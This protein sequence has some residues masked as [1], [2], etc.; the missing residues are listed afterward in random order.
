M[1]IG[2]E[3][4]LALVKLAIH[5]DG[6]LP[7]T[8]VDCAIDWKVVLEEA[9]KQSLAGVA[10][11]GFKRWLAS[12]TSN[13][14]DSSIDKRL[15]TDWFA[16]TESIREDNLRVN[17]RTAQVCHNFAKDGL[18]TSVMK[19]QGNASLY[20]EELMLLRASGD[21][22]VW[23]EGGFQKVYDYMEKVA[24]TREVDQMEI[25][26][27]AFSDTEVEVHYRPN[28]LRH[29]FRNRRLQQ[30][31]DKHADKC[32][33]HRVQ[34]LTSNLEGEEIWKDALI[35]TIPFNLVHQLAHILLHLFNEGVGLRQVMDYYYQ[36]VH[37]KDTVEAK[38]KE[39]VVKVVKDL[40]LDRL[41]GALT[42]VLIEYFGLPKDCQLWPANKED[43]EFLLEE[44]LRTGNF[45]H[46]D[47]RRPGE[48]KVGGLKYFLYVQKRN[49]ALLRFDRT[50]WFWG[51]LWRIYYYF[52]RRIH[53]FTRI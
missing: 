27:N 47:E 17:R 12:G 49:L 34:L 29:P 14:S 15:Y 22:D 8:L 46:D 1:T 30:F 44:I 16:L 31:I 39:E 4:L 7:K 37:A 35:T 21:I 42:W 23:V 48:L 51:S 18:R 5:P 26:F 20:G 53:G 32:F 52:W 19:G 40:N 25:K 33:T 9:K 43:G 2:Q 13:R 45:G 38:D 3:Q 50:N 24:P 41:A 6:E 28:I 11:V 36:L 10:F